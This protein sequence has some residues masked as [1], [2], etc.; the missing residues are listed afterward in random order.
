MCE[1]S[2]PEAGIKISEANFK[3]MNALKKFNYNHIYFHKRLDTYKAYAQLI[4]TSIFNLL[5]E[6]YAADKTITNLKK[7]ELVYPL[8]ITTFVEWLEKYAQPNKRNYPGNRYENQVIYNLFNQKDY[9]RAIVDFIA[10]MTDTFAKRV[11]DEIITF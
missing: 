11:F 5:K 1:N 3:A 2:S 4:I 8:L 6:L 7:H 9:L 10:G